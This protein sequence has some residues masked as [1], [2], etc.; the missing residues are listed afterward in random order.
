MVEVEN[1]SDAELF[2]D[3]NGEMGNNYFDPE[4]NALANVRNQLIEGEDARY[5]YVDEIYD[6]TDPND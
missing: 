3:E 4:V 6:Y 1:Y 2:I 5:D